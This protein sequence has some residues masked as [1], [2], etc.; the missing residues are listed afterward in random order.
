MKR[1]TKMDAT[2]MRHGPAALRT[3]TRGRGRP[4]LTEA[5]PLQESFADDPSPGFAR[6]HEDDEDPGLDADE[7]LAAAP[8]LAD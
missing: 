1:T 3:G 5:D 4:R 2:E 6:A 7:G 8:D